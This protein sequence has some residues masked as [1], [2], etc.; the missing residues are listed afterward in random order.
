VYRNRAHR[1]SHPC[2]RSIRFLLRA[3]RSRGIDYTLQSKR[4]QSLSE[5][6]HPQQII[7]EQNSIGQPIIEQLTR[8]GLRI[9]S[10]TT[11]NASKAQVIESLALAFERGDIR[12]PHDPV[13]IG[14]LVAYQAERL[15]SGLLRYGAPSGQH[16]DTVMALAMV[17]SAVTTQHRLVYPMPDSAIVV[18]DFHIPEHWPRAF[19]LD[20]RWLTM[21]AVWGALDPQSDVLYLYSEYFEEVESAAHVEAIR[22]RGAWIPGLFET[23]ANGRDRV[24]GNRLLQ[25][26]QSLGLSLQMV[27]NPLESGVLKL[28][29][30]MHTGR[31]KVCASLS[32]FLEQRRLYRR[33]DRECIV[34]E[35]DHL[36]D[37]ARCLVS[38]ID[39]LRRKPVPTLP[40]S[41]KPLGERSWMS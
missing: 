13:L 37:A 31:L 11:T 15:Q 12:I 38:G 8:E 28:W 3:E 41:L 20:I 30:R 22:K 14:E 17:W 26:Y 18:S 23:Q 35:R 27:N 21:A 33:D 25:M 29:E 2:L 19:G 39:R 10:F 6:W 40:A 36:V 7:A 16:D 24:D 34:T 9:D 5:R 4:L 1:E 32:Q